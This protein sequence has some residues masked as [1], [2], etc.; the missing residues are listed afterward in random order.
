[1]AGQDLSEKIIARAAGLPR[2]TPGEIV[3]CRVD[4]AMMH[5]SGGPRR[6]QADAR[7]ARRE[8]LGPDEVVLVSDHYVPAIDAESARILVSRAI[9]RA[10]KASPRFH[11]M[12]GICHVVLQERGHLR[13]GM[14]AVGGDSALDRRRRRRRLH[15]R[16]RRDRDAGRAR[17]R[18]DLG[19]VPQT[20]PHRLARRGSATASAPR[21]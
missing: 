6:R 2:V 15:V 16:R 21:I 7:R 1:M 3:T 8:D 17:D 9:G 12:Q 19:K 5:D 20:H 13:P 14:F 18:R 11:D 4:L 10:A